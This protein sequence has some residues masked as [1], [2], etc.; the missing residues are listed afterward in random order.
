DRPIRSADWQ[1]YEI[2]GD[3]ASDADSIVFGMMLIGGGVAMLDDVVVEV[4][5]G[6]VPTTGTGLRG[7]EPGLVVAVH[8][9]KATVLRDF[10]STTLRFPLPLAYRDQTPLTFRLQIEPADVDAGI[11]ITEGPGPN[12]T[13]EL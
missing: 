9:A 1:R 4:T 5:D 12:R 2:V 6:S 13:L 10:D 8:D 11:Q 3:V 7:G